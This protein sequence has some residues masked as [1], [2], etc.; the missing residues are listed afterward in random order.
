MT[1]PKHLTG[2]HWYLPDGTPMH[3]VEKKAG[4]LRPTTLADAKK[5]GNLLPSVTT[6]DKI[7]DKPQLN[8]WRIN[9][10]ILAACTTPRIEGESEDDFC[11]RVREV[12]AESVS[13]TAKQIGTD[14]HN[15]I[16][17]SLSGNPYELTLEPFVKPV[18]SAVLEM[19]RVVCLEKTLIGEDYAGRVDC[20]VENDATITI[21][22]FKTTGAK[23][24]PKKSYPEHQR[25]LAA[26]AATI[27]NTGNKRIQTA[28][29]YIS[30]VREGEISVCINPDW[31]D[32]YQAF[33][34]IVKLWQILN[35]YT[36][37]K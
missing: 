5:M 12:D 4:G 2:G 20:I 21:V 35:N 17:M 16:E 29:I 19:G 28:N 8:E 3:F 24:L 31:Q 14:V 27:G 1:T 13:D 23:A 33:K 32:S 37:N 34:L 25:Q 22:D 36:P 9:N 15:A 7:L 30:T 10:A 18:V 11:R 26:Y 6:I